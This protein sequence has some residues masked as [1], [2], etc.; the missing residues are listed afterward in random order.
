MGEPV[1]YLTA[2]GIRVKL[3]PIE[4]AAL[5]KEGPDG[6]GSFGNAATRIEALVIG[7]GTYV[8]GSDADVDGLFREPAPTGSREARGTPA[9]HPALIFDNVAVAPIWQNV[10]LNGVGSRVEESGIG[11]V[12]G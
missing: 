6:N 4:R 5:Q 1:V 2:A 10:P 8:Y 12:A 9:P 11:L 3:R 7:G